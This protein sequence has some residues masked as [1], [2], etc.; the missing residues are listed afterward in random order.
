LNDIAVPDKSSQSDEVAMW[1]IPYVVLIS[2][3]APAARPTL[4][5]LR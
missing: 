5:E 2:I 4:K 1:G 3:V